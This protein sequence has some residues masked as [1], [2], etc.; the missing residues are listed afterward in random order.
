MIKLPEDR[1]ATVM[2]IWFLKQVKDFIFKFPINESF[3]RGTQ[4][5]YM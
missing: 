3:C 1:N 2:L 5:Y 4:K